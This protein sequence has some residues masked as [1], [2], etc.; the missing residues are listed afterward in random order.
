MISRLFDPVGPGSDGELQ[1]KQVTDPSPKRA[2]NKVFFIA[3]IPFKKTISRILCVT[4]AEN[5]S[6][7]DNSIAGF[8]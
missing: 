6:N 1:P 7:S 2:I 8:H 5:S 3:H 4:T